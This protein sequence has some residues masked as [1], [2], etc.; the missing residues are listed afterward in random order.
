MRLPYTFRETVVVAESSE[1]EKCTLCVFP[2]PETYLPAFR[3]LIISTILAKK[4]PTQNPRCSC[5]K[6]LRQ[7][8]LLIILL[9]I[10]ASP[11]AA[12]WKLVAPN[13]IVSIFRPYNDGGVLINHNGILWA[14]YHNVW[15]S[16]DTGKTWSMRT[17]FTNFNNSCVKDIAFFDD[18]IGLATTQNGEIFTTNDQGLTWTQHI[19]ANP[20]RFRPSIESACF[21]G[22]PNNIIACSYAGDR[23]ISND[24]GITWNITLADSLAN[25][26]HSG[27]GGTAYIVGGF[28]RGLSAGAYL[29]ETNDFGASWFRH[30]GVFDWDSFSFE[31]DRCDTTVFYVVNDQ[32]ASK[33]STTSR[34]FVSN[35]TGITWIPHDV[36]PKQYHCGS[37]SAAQNAIYVQTYS[38]I[39]RSTDQG[40]SWKDIGGPPNLVDTRF[41]TAIDNNVIVAVDSFGSVWATYN[42]GGDSQSYNDGGTISI[43]TKD[44]QTDTIGG[45]VAVPISLNGIGSPIDAELT[46]HY[47][48]LLDYKGTYST[49][50]V[51]LDIP[52]ESWSGRSRVRIPGA[53][54]SGILA[55]SYF[56]V[57]GV[58]TMSTDVTF[59]S[60]I[61]CM[62]YLS[63][64]AT[65]TIT[66]NSS[67]STNILSRFMR[68][69]TFPQLSIMPNPTNGDISISS[70]QDLGAVNVQIFDMLGVKRIEK[71][72]ILH[73]EIPAKIL[74]T[75]MN[76]IYSI[77]VVS[78]NKIQDLIVVINR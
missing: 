34:V 56:D 78:S 12:Q 18:N 42:S 6:S 69:S 53:N 65:S 62:N 59:D 2:A 55:Y 10:V 29:Y 11:L 72:V 5:M 43:Q 74:L 30:P 66:P 63:A 51:K 49:N 31:R 41:V 4:P 67:C 60:V 20:F 46:V 71:S 48:S 26:V 25:Q 58:T 61:F 76:G 45:S 15:M 27:S 75:L 52:G 14:G 35:N 33:A 22:S 3:A 40:A 68:D 21:A 50:N 23:Y 54:S 77:R 39:S 8:K 13:A 70:S 38:G 28:D 19:P 57:Y 37:I 64:K 44:Q 24:R 17:P 9:L 16:S 7:P 47:N 32:L 36:Q 73:K 1:P